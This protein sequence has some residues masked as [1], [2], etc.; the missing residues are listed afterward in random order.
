MVVV[1]VVVA[2]TTA[3]TARRMTVAATTATV[4]VTMTVAVTTVT[5]ETEIVAVTMTRSETARRSEVD[6]AA[7]RVATDGGAV[8]VEAG[9]EIPTDVVVTRVTIALQRQS[10]RLYHFV[11]LPF[12]LTLSLLGVPSIVMSAPVCLSTHISQK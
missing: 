1:I 12:L 7:A 5:D 2:V 4:A 11:V 9:V 3:M 8:A 10:S 6:A